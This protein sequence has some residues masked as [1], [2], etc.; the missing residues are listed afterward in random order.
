MIKYEMIPEQ[1]IKEGTCN[2]NNFF[3]PGEIDDST[4]LLTMIKTTII[5]L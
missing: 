1:L 2:M 4:I 3:I 5:D